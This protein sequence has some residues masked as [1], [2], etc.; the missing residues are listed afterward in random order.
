MPPQKS[1]GLIIGLVVGILLFLGAS[2]FG[3]WAFSERQ[4]YKNDVDSKIET[5]VGMAV[6]EAEA[7]KEAEFVEREKSPL[8]TF[9]GSAT[10]GT[11]TFQYPKTWS[12]YDDSSNRG[13]IVVDVYAHPNVVPSIA[14]EQP[15][16]LRLE[17]LSQTYDTAVKTLDSAIKQGTVRAT[18]FR[19]AQLQDVLG[20]RF[21]G[22]IDRETNGVAIYLPLRDR[23]IRIATENPQ[24][25]TDFETIILPS[26][27]F[28][29]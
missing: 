13:S 5:A 18:A 19:P 8:R 14:S 4:S 29:P 7:A 6:M 27:T 11:V 2:G 3:V 12:I 15:Y 20:V 26:L 22:A 16:A 28:V 25:V 9:V 10:Y 23:T 24:F 1:T 21:E 17:V